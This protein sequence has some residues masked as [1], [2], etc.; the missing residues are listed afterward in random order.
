MT[1]AQ[2][3]IHPVAIEIMTA[4][5]REQNT[6]SK[7]KTKMF[8]NSCGAISCLHVQHKIDGTP[9]YREIS[10]PVSFHGGIGTLSS[11]FPSPCGLLQ[12]SLSLENYQKNMP[13]TLTWRSYLPDQPP[14]YR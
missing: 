10:H 12:S 11:A 4:V 5:R 1:L 6:T 14:L 3:L 8:L 9:Q 13:L 2:A 7:I